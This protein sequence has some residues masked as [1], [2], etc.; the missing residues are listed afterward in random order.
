MP[1]LQKLSLT[2]LQFSALYLLA[3]LILALPMHSQSMPTPQATPWAIAIHGGGGEEEWL[4][5]S[6][7]TAKA[8]HASLARALA[9]G[10]DVLRHGGKAIDAVQAAVEVLEDDPL[11][12]AGRGAAFAADGTNEME[13]PS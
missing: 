3:C 7:A 12:N 1:C 4:S 8:Y 9:V 5:M 11:F 6:A 2:R 13:P 10:A